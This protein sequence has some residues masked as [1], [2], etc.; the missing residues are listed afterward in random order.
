MFADSTPVEKPTAA[1]SVAAAAIISFFIVLFLCFFWVRLACIC[2][3][4]LLDVRTNSTSPKFLRVL[5]SFG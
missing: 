2:I 5:Y 4:S 3:E 1:Q